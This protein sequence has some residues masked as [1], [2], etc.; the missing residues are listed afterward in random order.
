MAITLND[1]NVGDIIKIKENGKL[2]DF[3]IVHKGN[4]STSIYD[5]SCDGVWLLRRYC[6]RNLSINGESFSTSNSYKPVDT[7]GNITSGS[8]YLYPSTNICHW[9]NN[10]YIYAFDELFR[11]N[12][13]TVKIPYQTSHHFIQISSGADGLT[14]KCFLLSCSEIGSSKNLGS[15]GSSNIYSNEGARLS[16]FS[17]SSKLECYENGSGFENKDPSQYDIQRWSLRSSYF[18]YSYEDHSTYVTVYQNNW[19]VT[20][21]FSDTNSGCRPAFIVSGNLNISDNDE[22]LAYTPSIITL[23]SIIKSKRTI[24]I[25]WTRSTFTTNPIYELYMTTSAS[26]TN[27]YEDYYN[28]EKVYTGSALSTSVTIPRTGYIRFKII[29]KDSYGN[30]S[31]ASMSDTQ[32]IK[33]LFPEPIDF[34]QWTSDWVEGSPI[35]F[36]WDPV[37]NSDGLYQDITY[38]IYLIDSRGMNNAIEHLLVYKGTDTSCTATIP[39]NWTYVYLVTSTTDLYE[40]SGDKYHGEYY[41]VIK[42]IENTTITLTTPMNSSLPIRSCI[43]SLIGNIPEGTT[44]TC[45]VTNNANDSTPIWENCI[46][47]SGYRIEHSFSN[48]ST[49]NGFSFNYQISIEKTANSPEGYFTSIQAVLSDNNSISSKTEQTTTGGLYDENDNLIA[50]WNELINTYKLDIQKDYTIN[51]Y[52]IDPSS[53]YY[54]F[55]N[56]YPELQSGVKLIIG[57]NVT[58][59]GN[60]AFMGC[61]LS[62]LKTIVISNS[63]TEINSSSFYGNSNLHNIII[64]KNVSQIGES[65]FAGCN[66]VIAFNIPNSTTSIGR[67]AFASCTSLTEIYI[68]D[69]VTNIEYAAFSDNNSLQYVY[70]SK[71]VTNIPIRLF[72]NCHNLETVIFSDKIISIGE[73]A[74]YNNY[75]LIN[76]TLPNSINT[77]GSGAFAHCTCLN[78]TIPDTVKNMESNAFADVGHIKYNGSLELD[79]Y[80]ARNGYEE[81][82]YIYENNTKQ[83]L[84][85]YT[86]LDSNITI[87]D[88]VTSIG[89]NAF[90]HHKKL[91][92]IIIPN[93]VIHIGYAILEDCTNLTS[94]TLS[95]NI[96][97]LRSTFANCTKLTSIIIPHSVKI[98]DCTFK[99]CENITQIELPNSLTE[100]FSSFYGC[101]SLRSITIP[102]NVSK[103]KNQSFYNCNN[104]SN[105]Y[106][107]Q[108]TMPEITE[109]CFYKNTGTITTFN[110]KNQAIYDAFLTDYYNVKF[111]TKSTD[112]NWT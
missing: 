71:Q 39:E 12:I 28:W 82:N 50:S 45:K 77:I 4:P 10:K 105:V 38:Y 98:L 54:V 78:I 46:E 107:L 33:L 59:I 88:C 31:S 66:N 55:C 72:Y 15:N 65:A 1:K 74:F 101:K 29:A 26:S 76:I 22:L 56:A 94:V 51:N 93:S 52:M 102:S 3:I 53:A 112:F 109:N 84:L 19:E 87:P 68:P 104:L 89:D 8:T 9:L 108:N 13:K 20:Y 81:N 110:F 57:N 69:S 5:S 70:L 41:T 23:P 34:I 6:F 64:G 85:A 83:K 17:D 40:C 11:N 63:I 43:L 35:Y 67:S 86:A 44:Y 79:Y 2:E 97:E 62:N 36:N 37:K 73:E 25:S 48:Q 100:L 103:I 91:C 58:K 106:F 7:N 90:H 111:G 24:P 27:Q 47:N 32:P 49:E 99:N 60:F 96:T 18:R 14:Q 80:I 21:D 75:N 42:N 92:N 30:S 16:Y 61:N 95:N